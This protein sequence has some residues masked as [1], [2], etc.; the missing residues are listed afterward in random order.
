MLRFDIIVLILYISTKHIN[1]D[2]WCTICVFWWIL[3][4]YTILYVR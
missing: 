4:Y 1:W 2:N 3:T